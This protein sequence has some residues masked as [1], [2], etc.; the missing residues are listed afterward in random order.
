MV[1]IAYITIL[2]RSSWALINTYYSVIRERGFRPDTIYVFTERT[3]E[4]KLEKIRSAISIISSGYDFKPRIESKVVSDIDFIEAG[5]E[6]FK[7]INRL[8]AEKTEI[9]IDITPGRRAL[10]AAALI[11]AMELKVD[12]IFYLAITSTEDA[13]KPY[14]MIPTQIQSINNFIEDSKKVVK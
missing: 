2:G 8:K 13:A 4:T 14:M 5:R 9:A 6:I 10:V 12:N 7:L 3:Y 11:P 1:K